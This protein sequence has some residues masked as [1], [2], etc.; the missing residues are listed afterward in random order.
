M[1]KLFI[2]SLLAFL[3]I[4]SSCSK[5]EIKNFVLVKGGAFINAKSS[6]YGKEVYVLDFYIGKY[7]ITQKE[8]VAIM[9]SNP[10][11]FKG[12]NL[13][14]ENV[15]WYE[16][17]EYCNKRSL[18]EGLKPYYT[19]D[20]NKKD[21]NNDNDSDIIKWIVTINERANGY[22]LPTEQE[23]EYAAVGGQMS[24]NY[25]YSGSNNI[26]KV[27]WYWCNSGDKNLTSTNWA[28]NTIQSNHCKTKPVGSKN[29]NEIGLYDMSGNVREW[30]W[31]WKSKDVEVKGR[32]WKGGAWAGGDY[33]SEPSFLR[34][35][36][37][38][39]PSND[40][41]FRVCRSE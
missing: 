20:K 30:C 26:D 4:I 40:L 32:A 35:Y 2:L 24:K 29:P 28:W 18:K 25:T 10:S 14:V 22:R 11:E 23:W 21:P 15:N 36:T 31:N 34:Y 6:Y 27:A 5:K 39:V 38:D 9:G 17:V 33:V 12:N 13:P 1:R 3:F 37:P 19:I 7:E 41:G 8:W 16:C